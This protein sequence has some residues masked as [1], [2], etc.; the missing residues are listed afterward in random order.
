MLESQLNDVLMIIGIETNLIGLYVFNFFD[1]YIG[2]Q[3]DSSSQRSFI[4]SS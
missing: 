2:M 3:K 4:N 1:M